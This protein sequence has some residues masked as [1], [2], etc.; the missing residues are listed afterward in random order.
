[1]TD[2]IPDRVPTDLVLSPEHAA[3]L[4]D[5]AIPLDVAIEAGARSITAEQDLPL[6]LRWAA[7]EGLPGILFGHASPSGEVAVPQYR[8]DHPADAQRKYLFPRGCGSVL[9]VHQRMRCLIGRATKCI[10]VEGTKQH[11]AAVAYAPSGTLVIGIQGCGSWSQ[12]GVALPSLD[13][14]ARGVESA[15]IVYDGDLAINHDVWRAGEMLAA[16]LRAL[17][18]GEVRYVRLDRLAGR[19]AGLDDYLASRPDDSRADVLARILS[20]DQLS[21]PLPREPRTTGSR[22]RASIA[23]VIDMDGGVIRETPTQNLT[24]QLEP[25]PVLIEAAARITR[26]ITITDDLMPEAEDDIEHDLEVV[27]GS[28]PTQRSYAVRG[29]PDTKLTDPEWWLR[30]VPGGAGT[31]VPRSAT[32]FAVD[33]QIAAA[34]RAHEADTAVMCTEYRRTGWVAYGGR[35][36]YLHAGGAIGPDGNTANVRASLP[37]VYSLI[38]LPN[39]AEY[40]QAQS[41]EALA[42]SWSVLDMLI[43]PTPWYAE[44]GHMTYTFA[45]PMP[46]TVLWLLGAPGSGKTVVDKT[47]MSHLAPA[48]GP[49]GGSVMVSMDSSAGDIGDSMAGLHQ[50]PLHIDDAR[51]RGALTRAQEAQDTGIELLCRQGYDGGSAGRGRLRL[52]PVTRRYIRTAA[53]RACAGVTVVGEV[54]PSAR[55]AT[56]TV[57]RI[58]SVPVVRD[59]S[60]RRGAERQMVDLARSGLPQRAT[61]VLLMWI[62]RRIA[63]LD[64]DPQRAMDIWIAGLETQ[65][66]AIAAALPDQTGVSL[67]ERQAQVAA[68]PLVGVALHLDIAA[69]MGA[70]SSAR[71]AAMMSEAGRLISAATARHAEVEMASAGGSSTMLDRLRQVVG[72]GR[73]VIERSAHALSPGQ[74]AIGRYTPTSVDGQQVQVVAILPDGAARAIG[75][76]IT[77]EQVTRALRDVAVLGPRGRTTRTVRIDGTQVGCICIPRALWSGSEGGE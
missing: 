21:T 7:R 65:R 3:Y 74:E 61:A 4:A 2:T 59:R 25:G 52:D 35:M 41:R 43:D 37:G 46:R 8:P 44:I 15:W 40:S 39:P 54:L 19:K 36:V 12:D 38:D 18:I 50:C 28:G 31:R 17:G 11:L 45:G 33:R 32:S 23:A 14:A 42:A 5:H 49:R 62:A 69:E 66:D 60:L 72:G 16:N 58:V 53:N 30:R 63:A 68:G 9:S 55:D 6:A 51:D 20:D 48:F 70:L 26:T 67:T 77:G 75:G 27:I 73:Y 71:A 22:Q 47:A 24:G 29:I 64:G 57:E 13:L 10:I 56:S 76:K 34:I 1:M